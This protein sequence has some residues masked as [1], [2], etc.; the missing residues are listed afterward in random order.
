M[1]FCE[2]KFESVNNIAFFK[3]CIKSIIH[4]LSRILAVFDK[5]EIGDSLN[6]LIL[7]LLWTGIILIVFKMFGN[8]LGESHRLK[9][10]ANWLDISLF[11]RLT[12][13]VGILF[14]L[15]AL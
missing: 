8:I 3:E 6:I 15:M 10:E 5:T 2:T 9:R 7:S 4:I 13:L 12:I 1:F 11:K 14:S